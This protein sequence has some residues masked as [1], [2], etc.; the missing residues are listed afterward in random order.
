M[1]IC[2][3]PVEQEITEKIKG[4]D[5]V[6]VIEERTTL[7]TSD[8][9]IFVPN[10]IPGELVELR[11]YRNYKSYSDADLMQVLEPSPDRVEPLC[12]LS[13]ICGGCQYQHM[14][15]EA[16]REWKMQQVQDGL[17]RIGGF[18]SAMIAAALEPTTGTD[19]IWN[20]RSK[21]TPHYEAP[22]KVG[23]ASWEIGCIGFKEKNSRRLVDVP[24]CAIA[25][26]AI[27]AE[28]T[29]VRDAKR[30]E[31]KEGLLRRPKKGATILLRDAN[32]GVVTDNN[33]YVTTTVAVPQHAN[34][35]LDFR[36]LAGNFFQNNPFML[37]VMVKYVV[38]AAVKGN[39]K[40]EKMTHL[41][42][43]YCGSGLFCL[44]SAASFEQCVGIEVNA[45]AVEEATANAELNGIEN[46]AF[47]AAS[48]EAIFESTTPIS[49]IVLA[50]DA[51]DEA[52]ADKAER[53]SLSPSL[54]QD[55]P[56]DTT[57]VVCD[58]PR[59]GCSEEFLE[60][61]YKFGPQRVVYMSCDA[62]TQARDAR[63]IVDAGY[64]IT[65]VQPFDLFPQTRH[66][67]CLMIFERTE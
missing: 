29:S 64:T 10:T 63:G 13:Q 9:V 34:G 12:P 60:Q 14:N 15:I 4:E 32:E 48:A 49:G 27:N 1:G 28:L 47:V 37:P 61:L 17:E 19:E 42:D 66:I 65:S 40:N 58:P 56:R 46:C 45:K 2:R 50:E 5:G 11:V 8:W 53:T 25:T 3:T 22:V 21:I 51:T 35:G 23:G 54:V 33:A 18:E 20:Y 31:A 38:E 59:K 62:S 7:K 16:Q 43:C 55:F 36:F 26:E 52:A 6:T 24:Q 57:V 41:I 67:E 44:S 30:L 39:A